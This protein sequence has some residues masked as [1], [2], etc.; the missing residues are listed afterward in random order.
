VDA[1]PGAAIWLQVFTLPTR[2]EPFNLSD[3]NSL[4]RLMLR[5]LSPD[6]LGVGQY[7]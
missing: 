2:Q 4:Q 5:C 1:R 6:E 3:V 7:R